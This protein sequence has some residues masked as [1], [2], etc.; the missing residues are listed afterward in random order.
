LE[1]GLNKLMKP[2]SIVTT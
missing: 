1:F 2:L